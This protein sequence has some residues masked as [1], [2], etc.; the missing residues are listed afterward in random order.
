MTD[1]P[2]IL[3]TGDISFLYDSNAFYGTITFQKLQNHFVE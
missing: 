3:I 1:L 2:T